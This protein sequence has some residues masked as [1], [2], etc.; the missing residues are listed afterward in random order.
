[1][2]SPHVLTLLADKLQLYPGDD[3]CSDEQRFKQIVDYVEELINHDLRRLMG[4]L[5]RIDVSEEK[6]KQALASQDKDQSSALILAK[7]M[8][9]RELEKVKFREQYKKARLKSSNS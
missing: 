1:M 8:V 7:L 6:I 2:E 9:E 5:Y 4:I 3:Q